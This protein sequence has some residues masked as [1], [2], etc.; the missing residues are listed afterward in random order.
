MRDAILGQLGAAFARLESYEWLDDAG[1]PQDAL[2]YD[3]DGNR[4]TW[5][6]VLRLQREGVEPEAFASIR[7]PV[8]MLHGDADPHPGP[9]T[10]DLLRRYMPQLEYVE[11]E[12]C[13][14]EPWREAHA[15]DHFLETLRAWLDGK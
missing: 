13:G 6:D 5:E 15:R 8:L 1:E 3:A 10:R 9:E 4:E 11:F 2:P 12:R 7:I 14:H